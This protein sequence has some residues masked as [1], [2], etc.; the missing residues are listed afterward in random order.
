M[1]SFIISAHAELADRELVCD[2]Q[3]PIMAQVLLAVR[4]HADA[5]AAIADPDFTDED[6]NRVLSEIESDRERA[7][8]LRVGRVR[9]RLPGALW[10]QA[11]PNED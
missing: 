4:D 3:R 8:E 1:T 11:A 6:W 2:P 5:L 9:Y 10:V 7:A